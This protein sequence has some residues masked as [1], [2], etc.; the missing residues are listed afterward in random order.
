M[1]TTQAL[2][3][4][5]LIGR[6]R[7]IGIGIWIW[8]ERRQE[9]KQSTLRQLGRA[10]PAHSFG[11]WLPSPPWAFFPCPFPTPPNPHPNLPSPFLSATLQRFWGAFQAEA[12]AEAGAK[13]LLGPSPLGS[14]R[15]LSS[16]TRR[17]WMHLK[18]TW[19]TRRFLLPVRSSFSLSPPYPLSFPGISNPKKLGIL[20]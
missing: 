18:T 20:L 7:A 9:G 17:N 13:A 4:N 15:L 3:G 10:L 6:S 12:E 14:S 16:S 1:L 11:R 19:Q 2:C 8:I 5:P